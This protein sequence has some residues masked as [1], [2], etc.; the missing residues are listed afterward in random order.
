MVAQSLALLAQA[1]TPA[2]DAVSEGA[3]WSAWSIDPEFLV[4]VALAAFFYA[5]GLA[6]WRERSREHARWRVVS[7]YAGLAVL[8]LALESPVDRLA[9]H[10]LTFHMLQHELLLMVAAPLILLGAPTTPSLLGMPRRLRLGVIRPLA[11]KRSVRGLY[12]L[13]THP[14]VATSLLTVMLWA[15]HLA[16]GWYDAA[17][18][19]DVVHDVQHVSY[20]V[21]GMLF[22]WGVIDPA[23][24]RA[25][26]PYPLRMVYLLVAGTPK[27][28]LA[29]LLTFASKP[30]YDAYAAAEPLV[31]LS[32]AD[33][34]S[35]GGL[36]M[37]APSQMMHLLAI[38]IV[39]FVW[40]HKSELDQQRSD[41][42]RLRL[43]AARREG[44]SSAP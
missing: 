2:H 22:W 39:F 18:R 32:R 29:A 19:D 10:H 42:E 30:L 26:M 25:R 15:W 37:W 40:A 31:G 43:E 33:D 36:I 35:I 8:V 44:A 38:A 17:L 21:V 41:A 7:Y 11:K 14:L 28:F 20:G 23:P 6:R 1:A 34:Q 3:W 9:A 4:P 5:R 12:R 16:P 13:A 24:L 27:H